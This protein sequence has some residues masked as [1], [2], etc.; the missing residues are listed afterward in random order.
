MK[1]N[2]RV[3]FHQFPIAKIQQYLIPAITKKVYFDETP[4]FFDKT[5]ISI[6]KIASRFPYTY[7]YI[8][9]AWWQHIEHRVKCWGCCYGGSTPPPF[10]NFPKIKPIKPKFDPIKKA[11]VFL[12]NPPPFLEN[13]PYFLENL[14]F[15]P[16]YCCKP[17]IVRSFF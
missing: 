5:P 17:W 3:A 16:N 2:S 12:K 10:C 7:I 14:P 6:D 4:Y 1:C 15:F 11:A 8:R 9:I 13:L